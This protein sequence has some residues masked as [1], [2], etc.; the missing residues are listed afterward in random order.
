MKI[1]AILYIKEGCP[2]CIDAER[3][4][5]KN[6]VPYER[7]DVLSNRAAM[8]EMVALTGQTLAP[9]MKLGDAVLADFGVDELVPFLAK[10]G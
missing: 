7:R 8:K 2:W 9:S 3:Y 4:L 5:K 6:K 1:K 10:H